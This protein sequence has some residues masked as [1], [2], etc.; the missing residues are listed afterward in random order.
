MDGA[1]GMQISSTNEVERQFRS[2][3]MDALEEDGEYHMVAARKR[4]RLMKQHSVHGASTWRSE[5][6]RSDIGLACEA[7]SRSPERGQKI[8][9]RSRSLESPGIQLDSAAAG[10]PSHGTYPKCYESL[11]CRIFYHV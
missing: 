2:L 5:W 11:R 10:S 9:R 7:G 6:R 3:S 4:R 8:T 1:S